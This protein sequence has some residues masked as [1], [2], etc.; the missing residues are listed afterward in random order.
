MNEISFP[1]QTIGTLIK[2]TIAAVVIA[3]IIFL[4]VVLPAEYGIDPTGA[5]KALGLT[6]LSK[7]VAPESIQTQ[8][9]VYELQENEATIVVRANMGVEYKFRMEKH[10]NLTYEWHSE[11]TSLHFDFH[12]EPKGDTTGYFESYTLAD[13]AQMKGSMTVPFDGVHGWYW[14]NTTDKDVTVTLKTKGHY[15]AI[16]LMH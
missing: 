11:G 14:K 15:E 3:V 8:I 16:G 10:A 13:S 5:G 7:T 9:S 2:A 4:T 6:V 1:I 12:G